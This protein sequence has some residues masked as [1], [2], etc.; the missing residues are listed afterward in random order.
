MAC[1]DAIRIFTD[2]IAEAF[3]SSIIR[4]PSSAAPM[5]TSESNFGIRMTPASDS[6]DA[7]G[8]K[9]ALDS[10]AESAAPGGGETDETA[11]AHRQSE[12]ATPELA[13]AGGLGELRGLVQGMLSPEAMGVLAAIAAVQQLNK[14]IEEAKQNITAAANDDATS[15]AGAPLS[16]AVLSAVQSAALADGDPQRGQDN[17]TREENTGQPFPAAEA[18]YTVGHVTDD[19]DRRI[20]EA[21]RN[22]AA[23]A[24]G[25]QDQLHVLLEQAVGVMEALMDQSPIARV[26]DL[27]RRVAVLEQRANNDRTHAR[28]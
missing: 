20:T 24:S 15:V 19:L 22:V 7:Q 23:R 18:G 10:V 28:S 17:R 26:E 4:H 12:A 13:A 21:R 16:G 8:A 1:A 27:K 9:S 3:V 25:A 11:V 6:S 5:P 2:A 14:Y